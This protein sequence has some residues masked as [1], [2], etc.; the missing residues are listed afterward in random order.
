METDILGGEQMGY[1]TILV[2]TGST[3]RE[4]LSS[5]AYQPDI[6]VDSIADLCETEKLLREIMPTMNREDDTPH[7]MREWAAAHS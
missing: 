6:V 4:D 3:K 7:D 2:L 1:R 5:Y